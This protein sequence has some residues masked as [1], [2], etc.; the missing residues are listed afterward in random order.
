MRTKIKGYL[1]TVLIII[2]CVG[3]IATINY[4]ML[5][6]RTMEIKYQVEDKNYMPMGERPG[7][8]PSELEGERLEGEP[9]ESEGERPEGAPPELEGGRPENLPAELYEGNNVKE[10]RHGANLKYYILIVSEMLILGVGIMYLIITKFGGVK[11]S[12]SLITKKKK[13]IALSS[14][15]V[16]IIISI[17]G[18]VLLVNN[19]VGES[20]AVL[21]DEDS[22]ISFADK[23]R[24]VEAKSVHIIDII[25]ITPNELNAIIFFFFVIKL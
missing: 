25:I 18:S 22:K 9:L 3:M 11:I 4:A 21:L 23:A 20:N 2:A 10:E 15:G 7:A 8:V 17:F 19:L 1:V 13:I 16:I 5:D 24:S 12:Q 14:L 6:S